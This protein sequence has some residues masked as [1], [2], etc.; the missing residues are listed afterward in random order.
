MAEL[1]SNG[2]EA[3]LVV[4]NHDMSLS[5][6]ASDS[7]PHSVFESF[8]GPNIFLSSDELESREIEVDGET[9]QI[10]GLSYNPLNGG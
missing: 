10:S 8:E 5:S 6:E 1:Q 3:F 2:I 7:S 4:G 9:V